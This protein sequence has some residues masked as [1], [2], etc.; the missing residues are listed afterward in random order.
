MPARKVAAAPTTR[1]RAHYCQLT[2]WMMSGVEVEVLAEAGAE[3]GVE[4]AASVGTTAARTVVPKMGTGDG[5]AVDGAAAAVAVAVAAAE[6]RRRA[7]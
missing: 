2:L 4:G 6:E 3:V 1:S 7:R 5:W